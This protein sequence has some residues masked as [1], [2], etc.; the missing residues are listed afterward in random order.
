M[1]LLVQR[2]REARVDIQAETVGAIEK[3]LLVF[4]GLGQGDSEA[5]LD[6]A[7]HKLLNLRVFHDEEGKMNRN[8]VQVDGGL[9]LVSQFTL[10]G[11]TKKGHRP[12]FVPAA[13][14]DQAEPLYDLLAEKV[15]GLFH[16][17]LATG[18]FGADMQ[19]HLV[20]DGPVTLWLEREPQQ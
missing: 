9:L 11:D 7:V 4:V 8:V 6:W 13:H 16:G 12:S 19:V 14:P 20:N 17:P 18:R 2:V 3:G 5:E 15:R 1:R 10:Y